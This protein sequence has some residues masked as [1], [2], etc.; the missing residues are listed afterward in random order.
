MNKLSA[1]VTLTA[2]LGLTACAG[3]RSTPGAPA[4]ATQT[5]SAANTA[6][7]DSAAPAPA[8]AAAAPQKDSVS[9]AAELLAAGKEAEAKTMLQNILLASPRDTTAQNFLRQ[10]ESDP[11]KL[12]GEP[13]TEPYVV[14]TGDTMSGLADRFLGDGRL[15]YALSRYN[16]LAA[17]N[18]LAVGRV[19]KLPATAK[20]QPAKPPTSTAA[21][22]STVSLGKA[23]EVRLQ[24]LQLLNK[25]Q[26]DGAV[27]LL[28]QAVSLDGNDAAIRKDLDRAKRIQSALIAE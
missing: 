22:S 3:M 4:P 20:R 14:Q 25:G 27:K 21:T 1:A 16:G 2:V 17:P 11:I 12:L 26:V 5:A 18:A 9:L 13:S 19:L 10:I 8:P 7:T 15:F 23:N 24:A 28:E 6:P